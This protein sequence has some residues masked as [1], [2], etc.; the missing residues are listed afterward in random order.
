MN[1]EASFN[2]AAELTS[3]L[4]AFATPVLGPEEVNAPL[5]SLRVNKRNA[6]HSL[7][8]R[9]GSIEAINNIYNPS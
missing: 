5:T 2:A 8:Q 6:P 9:S 7:L 1:G 4:R 3:E